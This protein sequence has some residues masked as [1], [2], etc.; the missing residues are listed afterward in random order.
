MK[1]T[2][3]IDESQEESVVVTAHRQSALTDDIERLIK[4]HTS[5]QVLV[6]YGEDDIRLLPYDSV[7]CIAV[8]DGK[9]IAIDTDG[10]SWRLKMRLYEIEEQLP[11]HFI[12]INKSAIANKRRIDTF[13]AAF[14]GAVNV[15]MKC[16]YTDYV[17]RRCLR[18]I[19]KELG[20]Q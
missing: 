12:R 11:S 17:S 8:N 6:G 10:V 9:T 7:E 16:G 14:S 20:K 1:Y 19:K 18:N 13:T 5:E 2:L 4:Q 15:K 3:I